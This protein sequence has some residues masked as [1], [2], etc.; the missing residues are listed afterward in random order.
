MTE[1][2]SVPVRSEQG[3][4]RLRLVVVWWCCVVV[5]VMVVL[6]M[7]VV[8]VVVM[9]PGASAGRWVVA[10]PSRHQTVQVDLIPYNQIR[11]NIDRLG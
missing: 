8:M 4:K 9:V 3:H 10:S 1:S 7:V 2:Q 6:V 11:E 5:V